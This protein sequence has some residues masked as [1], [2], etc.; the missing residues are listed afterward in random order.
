MRKNVFYLLLLFFV[1]TACNRDD[2]Q[3]N[4]ASTEITQKDPLT[5]KQINEKI[6]ETIKTKGRFSWNE[7]SDHFLWS[8]IFQGNKIASIGFGSS[9]DRSL[10]ADNKAIEHEILD[11]IKKYEGKTDRILLSSDQYLNQIDVA[12][13]VGEQ[14]ASGDDRIFGVMIESHLNA[15]RQ[16]LVPGKELA[17]GVSIT[18]ACIDWAQTEGVLRQLAA[19]VQR[20]RLARRD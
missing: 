18:D 8:G 4:V 13:E 7:S 2:L 3:N 9:F 10:D 20:R 16:D 6:N 12:I 14:L 15:G 5:A 19:D 11:L 1:F 17:Y